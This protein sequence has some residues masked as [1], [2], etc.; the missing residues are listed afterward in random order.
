[1]PAFRPLSLDSHR[2]SFSHFPVLHV[3][4][5]PVT[6]TSFRLFS[7]LLSD[8]HFL[9]PN[10]SRRPKPSLTMPTSPRSSIRIF[11]AGTDLTRSVT[12]QAAQFSPHTR[13]LSALSSTCS[14]DVLL[15]DQDPHHH[16]QSALFLRTK[17]AIS[18]V[19]TFWKKT[20]S[21]SFCV[22]R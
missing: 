12:H 5:F 18:I 21:L 4:L 6:C 16:N 20:S 1:M 13:P 9:L 15:S 8:Q 17:V 14:K 2:A 22:L 11:P 19:E 10:F 7:L 3:P